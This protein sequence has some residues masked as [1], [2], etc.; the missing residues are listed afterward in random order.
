VV[1]WDKAAWHISREGRT[2]IQTHTRR[3]KRDGGCRLVL[4]Q[5]PTQNPWLNRIAPKWVHG[6]RAIAEPERKLTVEETR[7]R[8][9]DYYHCAL[10]APLAQ[11]V[12]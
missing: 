7:Q 3:V 12:A 10:L 6:K 11:R 4:C 5:L 9:C 8:S 1:V 2:W